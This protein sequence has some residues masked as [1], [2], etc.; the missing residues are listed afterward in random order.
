MMTSPLSV[1]LD[2]SGADFE[3]PLQKLIICAK[4]AVVELWPRR[5]SSHPGWS[6]LK[7]YAFT[8]PCNAY[9]W[10]PPGINSILGEWKD[11]V[12]YFSLLTLVSY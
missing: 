10:L 6:V 5:H 7:P 8:W 12:S 2:P 3:S 9:N 4:S 11:Y 1:R